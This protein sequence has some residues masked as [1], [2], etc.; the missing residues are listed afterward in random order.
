MLQWGHVDKIDWETDKGGWLKR[1]NKWRPQALHRTF[2]TR[3]RKTRIKWKRK[4]VNV[5]RRFPPFKADTPWTSLTPK[6]REQLS[7]LL[8]SREIEGSVGTKW[9]KMQKQ[10]SHPHSHGEDILSGNQKRANGGQ[11]T[12]E[13]GPL[14]EEGEEAEGDEEDGEGESSEEEE[15]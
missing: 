12:A 8:P 6:N 15:K 2:N 14:P 9:R 4:E 10:V 1:G 13:W 3:I 7:S 5:I 11:D